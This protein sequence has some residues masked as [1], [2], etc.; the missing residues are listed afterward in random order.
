MRRVRVLGL[1]QSLSEDGVWEGRQ[2]KGTGKTGKRTM[3]LSRLWDSASLEDLK[4]AV[5]TCVLLESWDLHGIDD[6]SVSRPVM[7]SFDGMF[8]ERM[9]LPPSSSDGTRCPYYEDFTFT[10]GQ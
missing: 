8:G 7:S 4:F 3:K 1:C 9:V 6:F 10:A 5:L 2:E